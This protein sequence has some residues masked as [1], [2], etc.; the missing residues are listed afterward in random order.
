M[1]QEHHTGNEAKTIASGLASGIVEKV[2]DFN[3]CLKAIYVGIFVDI[4]LITLTGHGLAISSLD[5]ESL[6]ANA[7]KILCALLVFMSFVSLIVPAIV[8]IV[9]AFALHSSEYHPLPPN[10]VW[11]RDLKRLALEENSDFLLNLCLQHSQ[12]VKQRQAKKVDARSLLIGLTVLIVT[13]YISGYIGHAESIIMLL[14]SHLTWGVLVLT[15]LALY[16]GI[17]WTYQE[18][19]KDRWILYPP[20]A[21]KQ[22]NA[23][24]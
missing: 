9:N 5:S 11:P 16:Y 17:A 23:Q 14:Q 4:A 18:D 20:L 1:T 3:W 15:L 6:L 8:H 24:K 2:W 10:C 12:D 7:G 13:D 22:S 21:E 19:P